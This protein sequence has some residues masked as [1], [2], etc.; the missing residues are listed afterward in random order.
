MIAHSLGRE[1]YVVNSNKRIK[2]RTE[3]S[4]ANAISKWIDGPSWICSSSSSMPN[5]TKHTLNLFWEFTLKSTNSKYM[6]KLLWNQSVAYIRLYAYIH[7]TFVFDVIVFYAY[8]IVC[9]LYTALCTVYIC[10]AMLCLAITICL[11]IFVSPKND[12][13]QEF[14]YALSCVNT[15]LPPPLQK[16]NSLG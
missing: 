15:V 7:S 9:T 8:K 4:Q 3:L 1:K 12:S 5:A 6:Y 16:N 13:W 14:S 11:V 10:L 2:E